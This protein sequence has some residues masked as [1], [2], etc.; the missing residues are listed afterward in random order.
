MSEITNNDFTT[1][2]V[3]NSVEYRWRK[4][5]A[6]VHFYVLLFWVAISFVVFLIVAAKDLDFFWLTMLIWAIITAVVSTPFVCAII[7]HR[8]KNKYLLKHFAEFSRHEVILNKP[9]SSINYRRSVYYTVTICVDG[10]QQNVNTNACFSDALL[11]AGMTIDEYNNKIVAGLYDEQTDK[12][13]VIKKPHDD[14]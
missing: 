13:Y 3:K 7:Y 11:S 6:D 14:K 8:S 4:K 10:M 9:H 12:F 2:D 5:Q 1:E